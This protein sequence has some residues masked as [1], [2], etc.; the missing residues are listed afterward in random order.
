[1]VGLNEYP[2]SNSNSDNSDT[3]S[4]SKTTITPSLK[5]FKA[6][7][8]Q[9]NVKSKML[10]LKTKHSMQRSSPKKSFSFT[11]LSLPD[12]YCHSSNN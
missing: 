4:H 10:S 11:N 3:S 9:P 6:N 2:D 5:H 12:S 8:Q 1:M 7:N